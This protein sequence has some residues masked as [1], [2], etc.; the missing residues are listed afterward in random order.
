LAFT[1][2]G[3]IKHIWRRNW[4][5]LLRWKASLYMNYLYRTLI[6]A[7]VLKHKLHFLKK[8]KAVIS[9]KN[10]QR[11]YSTRIDFS[12]TE[13]FPEPNNKLKKKFLEFGSEKALFVAYLKPNPDNSSGSQNPTQTQPL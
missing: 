12:R 2:F 8:L 3:G 4:K 6:V 13:Y 11:F 9:M 5:Y 7:K 10:F 1:S